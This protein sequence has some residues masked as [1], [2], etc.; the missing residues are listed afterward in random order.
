MNSE[1][2]K[3]QGFTL[4]EADSVVVVSRSMTQGWSDTTLSQGGAGS[5][6]TLPDLSLYVPDLKNPDL[7]REIIF[8][9]IGRSYRVDGLVRER[10]VCNPC[11]IPGGTDYYEVIARHSVD[12]EQRS[13]LITLVR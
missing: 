6:F 13:G 9:R 10:E 1:V 4:E 11:F 2:I 8:P 12:G 7:Q 5:Y 3:L